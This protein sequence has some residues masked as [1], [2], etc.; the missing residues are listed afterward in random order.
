MVIA[1]TPL[2]PLS[3]PPADRLV[4]IEA[5]SDRF[6]PAVIRV[7]PGDHITIELIATDVVHGIHIE[8]YDINLIADPGQ[9]AAVSFIADREGTFTFRCSIA[10]GPLHPFLVGRLRVGT[11]AILWRAVGLSLL[12]AGAAIW[13]GR[14]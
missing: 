10:C 7:N 6:S 3:A 14:R 1:A 12:I 11:N 13:G 9:T 2:P 4:R 5:G 8:G